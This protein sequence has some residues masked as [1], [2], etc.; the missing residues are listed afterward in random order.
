[1]EM[2]RMFY[3]QSLLQTDMCIRDGELDIRGLRVSEQLPVP[4]QAK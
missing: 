2:V 1:M 4:S 3:S